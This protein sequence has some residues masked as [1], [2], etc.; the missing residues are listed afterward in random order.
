MKM[1]TKEDLTQRVLD[2]KLREMSL[3][4]HAFLKFNTI[5]QMI[6]HFPQQAAAASENFPVCVKAKQL[7]RNQRRG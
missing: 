2:E 1:V 5:K 4:L 7:F 3:L 6:R